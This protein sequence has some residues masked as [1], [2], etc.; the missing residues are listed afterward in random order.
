M[1]RFRFIQRLVFLAIAAMLLVNCGPGQAQPTAM[2]AATAT[3]VVIVVTSPPT[4]TPQA[5][6]PTENTTGKTIIS[7]ASR[8]MGYQTTYMIISKSG[9]VIVADPYRIVEGIKADIITSSHKDYDHNDARFY[10]A[11]ECKKSLYTVEQFSV[12]DVT[13][14]SIASSHYSDTIDL[15]NP[16]NVI[17]VFDVDGLRIAHLGD[18]WQSSLTPEQLETLGHVDIVITIMED[19][20][21]Y[22]FTKEKTLA[23]LKQL[24]PS[25]VL[26]THPERPALEAVGKF[27]DETL[28]ESHRWAVSKEDLQDGKLRLVLLGP[29]PKTP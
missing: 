15:A 29:Y 19:Q 3:P 20:P 7:R 6:D 28:Q 2:P 10:A 13:V 18:I 22:G 17:Y 21:Y 5:P 4:P 11:N 9:T 27:V 25:V 1:T 8:D 26:P 24:N 23:I 16:S 12:K 14:T